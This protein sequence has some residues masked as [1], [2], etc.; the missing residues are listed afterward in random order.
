MA[1]RVE[2]P[3]GARCVM[4]IELRKTPR[5]K[6]QHLIYVELGQD[7]GGMMRD[8]S[9]NGMGFRSMGPLQRGAKVPFSFSFSAGEMVKG[10]AE[11]IWTDPEGRSG[12][13]HFVDAKKACGQIRRWLAHDASPVT[14]QDAA[15]EAALAEKGSTFEELREELRGKTSPEV[16]ETAHAEAETP[17]AEA[18]DEVSASA[19]PIAASTE[20]LPPPPAVEAKEEVS[21]AA[22]AETP[23]VE[24]KDEAS[25][26]VMPIAASTEILPTAPAETPFQKEI[27]FGIEPLAPLEGTPTK[28]SWVE[29]VTLGSVVIAMVI[30]TLLAASVVYH[31]E[32]GQSLIWLGAR[33]AGPEQTNTTSS[34]LAQPTESGTNSSPGD[35][36]SGLADS[37]AQLQTSREKPKTQTAPTQ[38][39]ASRNSQ[40]PTQDTNQAEVGNALKNEGSGQR[41]LQQALKILRGTGQSEDVSHAVQLLWVAVRRGNSDAEVALADLYRTGE[42]VP[43]N[44][45][46]TRVL[47]SAAAKKGNSQA[48]A[49]LREIAQSGCP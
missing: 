7:N 47:L 40:T 21:A 41:E 18:K 11:L 46:Q 20:M 44:C 5:K 3:S 45:D 17:A 30:L 25:A 1:G 8:L 13:L 9:E 35:T 24:A 28:T 2:K 14:V 37:T 33:I 26:P 23:A 6:P 19:M 29:N 48:K 31:R 4:D 27:N 49:R 42:G 36:A 32:L 43:Q 34:Q 22:E 38:A 10:E 12:G 16:A 15:A 39:S